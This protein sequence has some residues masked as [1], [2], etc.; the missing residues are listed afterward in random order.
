ML[1]LTRRV[2]KSL[3]LEWG[4]QQIAITMLKRNSG[5]IK[6]GITAPDDVVIHRGQESFITDRKVKS[7]E[8]Q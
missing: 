4:G 2:G 7:K 1:V 6:L 5:R 8:S 3:Y